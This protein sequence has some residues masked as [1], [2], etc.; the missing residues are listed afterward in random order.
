[1]NCLK[2]VTHDIFASPPIYCT[3]VFLIALTFLLG[4]AVSAFALASYSDPPG[5]PSLWPSSLT[6]QAY[7]SQ[8]QA[9][10]DKT[11][12]TDGSSA[13]NP[14]GAADFS[15][16][17]GINEPSFFYYGD[18]SILYFRFRLGGNPL[19]LTGNGQPFG[20]ITWNVMFD[21][22]GDGYK[23]FVM[24]MDG[25]DSGTQPDDIV[26]IY[27][28]TLTQKFNT[29]QVGIW[30][31]DS[32]GSND[33]VNG[34]TGT[35]SAWD[36]SSDLYVW[37]FGRTR[38][39]QIDQTKTA[40]TNNSEYFLDV[41]IPLSAFDATGIGGPLLTASSFFSLS[42]TSS[43]SNTDPTQKDLIYSGDISLA[44]VPLPGGDLSNSSGQI[45]Q[46]P[47][48]PTISATS[49]PS[50]IIITATVLDA[51]TVDPVTKLTKDT[52]SSVIFQYFYDYNSNG[53]PDDIGQSWTPIGSASRTAALGQWQYSWDTSVLLN[54]KYLI[55]AIATDILGYVTTSTSQSYL[56]PSSVTASFTN[57]CS[58]IAILNTSTKSVTDLNGGLTVPGDTLSYSI[59]IKN[60]G[61]LNAVNIALKDTLDS[62]LAYV[63]GSGSP[64]PSATN[65]ALLW[66]VGTLAPSATAT[67]TFRA[68][69]TGPIANGTQ[70]LNTGWITYDSGQVTGLTRN[71]TASVTVS[72]GP[73]MSFVKAVSRSTA[74]PGEILTYTVSYSNIGTDTATEVW[75]SDTSPPNTDYV[76]NSVTL[77]GAGKTDA[78]DSD[79]ATV[80]GGSVIIH[81]GSVSAGASGQAQFQVKI[82]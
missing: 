35:S 51:L 33:G 75:I 74:A 72:S 60:T 7:T 6:T 67:Y 3:I 26:V 63:T 76:A 77:N 30:R 80:T 29:T 78:A 82:K 42:V 56:T 48:I 58:N 66:N 61:G 25:T 24:M 27:D 34:A 50:P 9:Q 59:S 12:S 62:H 70:I 36:L 71:V 20:S 4:G 44:D 22:D 55:R 28:N 79:E 38:V 49:C 52:L 81:I 21:V 32:A 14:T 10:A 39:V 11:G 37:D 8:G 19:A 45:L 1:M 43:N 17:S 69:I 57:S 46:A 40:G 54:G 15:S 64:A 5:Y 16:G 68:V 2:T 47:A 18:G 31:Q 41:Q 73:N 23:E 13:A 65:P 53:L